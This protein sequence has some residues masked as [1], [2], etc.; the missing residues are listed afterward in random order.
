VKVVIPMVKLSNLHKIRKFNKETW[1]K[2]VEIINKIGK[3]RNFLIVST[4][5]PLL[6]RALSIE[7]NTFL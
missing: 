4:L 6:T 1:G 3:N 5:N 2:F 7:Y